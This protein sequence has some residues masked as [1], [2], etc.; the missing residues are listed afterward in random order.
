M[1]INKAIAPILASIALGVVAM[2]PSNAAPTP[3]SQSAFAS[4]TGVGTDASTV[5]T[6]SG[7]SG[8][9]FRTSAGSIFLG[10][11]LPTAATNAPATLTFTGFSAS[12]Q[13]TG[14]GSS[15]NPYNQGLG[16]G[17]FSLADASNTLLT[18]TFTGGNVLTVIYGST[19]AGI[20]NTVNNVTYTGGSYFLSSGLL[21]P[22]SFSTTMVTVSPSPT[23]SS[24][25]GYLTAF[26]AGGSSVFSATVPRVSTVPEPATVAP[27]I[28]G[29]LGL[30]G[31]AF[32]A[33]KTRRSNGA[34]A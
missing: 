12:G 13:A 17:T 6:Y 31:L 11:F 4:A 7:G 2:V 25:D 9:T 15:A 26:T 14:D 30:M 29:G 1:N 32:R 33:R 18:G 34:A 10:T 5:F 24:E 19:T 3:G 8:G 23:V 16:A 20:T 21:N 22:G 28:M 27:F